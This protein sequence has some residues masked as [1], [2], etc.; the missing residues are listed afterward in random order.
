MRDEELVPVYNAMSEVDALLYRTMLEEAGIDVV[1]RPFEADWLEGVRQDGLHSQLLV[2]ASNVADART[3]V[4]DFTREAENG[5]L[6]AEAEAEAT[7]AAEAEA[8]LDP[9]TASTPDDR[10]LGDPES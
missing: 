2:A 6:A 7:P 5:E 3:L 1:E 9:P 4:E 10:E 8:A